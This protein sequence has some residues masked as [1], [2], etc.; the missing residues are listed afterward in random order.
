MPTSEQKFNTLTL[1]WWFCT[2]T[3]LINVNLQRKLF[4]LCQ[5]FKT[6]KVNILDQHI[7]VSLAFA[8]LNT[9]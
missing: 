5:Y 6:Q 3:L 1:T 9:A 8:V 2:C 4:S 7:D